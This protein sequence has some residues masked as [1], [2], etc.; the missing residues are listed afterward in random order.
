MNAPSGRPTPSGAPAPSAEPT[1]WAETPIT[2][3]DSPVSD[4]TVTLGRG[5]RVSGRLEFDGT[6]P[7][8][9]PETIE[10]FS[11]LLDPIDGHGS[12]MPAAFRGSIDRNGR[13]ST[14]EVPPGRYF[15]LFLAFADDRLKMAGW[16]TKGAT[17]HGRDVSTFP[18]DL[19]EDVTDLVMTITDHPSEVSGVVRTAQGQIDAGATVLWFTADKSLWVN[20]GMSSRKLR[21]VRAN[22]DGSFKVRGIPAGEYFLAALPDEETGNWQNPS[23]LE[24]ISRRAVRVSIADGEKRTQDIVTMSIR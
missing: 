15:V 8:P 14:N 10:R 21:S 11:I 17:L 3:G 24:A 12:Q 5:F 22:E 2:V 13:I 18:L 23:L 1:L 4:L 20:H 16:E 19:T 9:A 7:K 6:L